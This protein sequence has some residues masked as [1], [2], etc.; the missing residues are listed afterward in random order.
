MLDPV[1]RIT[2]SWGEDYGMGGDVFVKVNDFERLLKNGGEA[3]IP[4]RRDTSE[5]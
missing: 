4:M 3:C 2:N 1:L 5:A